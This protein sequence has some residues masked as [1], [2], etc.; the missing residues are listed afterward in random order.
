MRLSYL[1]IYTVALHFSELMVTEEAQLIG[2]LFMIFD[3]FLM[4]A[5]HCIIKAGGFHRYN[6]LP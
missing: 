5:K 2:L 4:E 6:C 1:Y 3:L